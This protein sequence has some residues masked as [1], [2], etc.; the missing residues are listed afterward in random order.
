MTFQVF[1]DMASAGGGWNLVASVH[2]NDITG[3]CTLGDKWSSELGSRSS[4][5]K[6]R[7]DMEIIGLLPI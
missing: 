2:E 3:K 4:T 5:S 6:G 7:I 1:C